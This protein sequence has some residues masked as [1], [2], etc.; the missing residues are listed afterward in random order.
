[1]IKN[2]IQTKDRLGL[3]DYHDSGHGY[4]CQWLIF[5]R[6]WKDETEKIPSRPIASLVGLEAKA[7]RRLGL[8]S[9]PPCRLAR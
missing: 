9:S 1:M 6:T 8:G 5:T 2:C 4:R 3:L 7:R